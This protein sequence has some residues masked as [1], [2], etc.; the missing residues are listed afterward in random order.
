MKVKEVALVRG[1]KATNKNSELHLI[2]RLISGY[3]FDKLNDLKEYISEIELKF[4]KDKKRLNK[5]YDDNI[6]GYGQ[7]KEILDGIIEFYYEDY[8]KI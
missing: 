2:K 6:N 3:T 4:K 7:N 8:Y 1:Q 5:R